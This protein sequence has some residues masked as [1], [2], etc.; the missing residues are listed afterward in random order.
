MPDIND[1][2]PLLPVQPTSP[3]R[4]PRRHQGPVRRQEE[5]EDE[6]KPR[7]KPRDDDHGRVIDE[8]A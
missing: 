7:R 1:G 8:Y 2:Q 6:D 3:S 5:S 4:P